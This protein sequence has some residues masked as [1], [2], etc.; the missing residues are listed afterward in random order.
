MTIMQTNEDDSDALAAELGVVIQSMMFRR[1]VTQRQLGAALGISQP[2]VS[3]K[4]RGKVPVTVPE[5]CMIARVLDVN[6]G[7]LL[8]VLPQLDSNQQP[9]GYTSSLVSAAVAMYGRAV[10]LMQLEDIRW[11]SWLD[12]STQLWVLENDPGL[13]EL[14]WVAR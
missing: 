14:G 7:D 3:A 4:L 10:E 8:P 1:R 13:Y 9:F 12:V 11:V 5:L 2:S 6:P